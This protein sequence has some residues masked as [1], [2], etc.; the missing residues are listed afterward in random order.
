MKIIDDYLPQEKVNALN[1]LHIEY[2]KVHWIG[3]EYK[4]TTNPL[5]D[6]VMSTKSTLSKRAHGATVWYNVR[7]ID[8]VWHSDILSYNDKYPTNHLPEYTY[9]YYMREPDSGGH[10]EI[11]N[12]D[13]A[14]NQTFEPKTNRLLYFDATLTHR[15]QPYEGN[16]V[17]VAWVWWQTPPDRYDPAI[18]TNTSYHVLERV[19]K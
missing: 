19:W 13:W 6:L 2:A 18:L 9:L 8:P 12:E 15:V 10:L 5:I 17:S 3:W 16:R 11:G 7:P 14:V 1:A 4:R